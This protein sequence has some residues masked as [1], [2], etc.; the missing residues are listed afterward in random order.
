MA[1]A[2]WPCSRA[3]VARADGRPRRRGWVPPAAPEGPPRGG[4]GVRRSGGVARKA[5]ED[6]VDVRFLDYASERDC[7]LIGQLLNE[8]AADSMGGGN[9]LDDDVVKNVGRKLGEVPGAVS[10]AA[11]DGATNEPVGLVNA[12]PGFSTFRSKPLLNVHDVMVREAY[13]GKGIAPQ[14]LR[15]VEEEAVR[16]GC[17][18][19][20]LEVLSNNTAAQRSYAKMGFKA[21]E[22]DPTAGQAMFWEKSL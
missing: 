4:R 2:L 7:A 8:Y 13:R 5:A 20:T 19:L 9:P 18:K 16:R 22:L 17:C 1:S 6:N 10:V 21:Y 14:M 12:L 11:F 15:L 3:I